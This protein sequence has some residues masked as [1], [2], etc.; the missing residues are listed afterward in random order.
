MTRN[1]KLFLELKD[2]DGGKVCFG[3]KENGKIIGIGKVGNNTKQISGVALERDLKFN[4]VSVSQLCDKGFQVNF[5]ANDVRIIDP[6]DAKTLLVG[7]SNKEIYVIDFNDE[8]K[9]EK[10]LLQLVMNRSYGIGD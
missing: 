4:L 9:L 8:Q 6:K 1:K 7:K 2:Y 5:S 3:N 10:S